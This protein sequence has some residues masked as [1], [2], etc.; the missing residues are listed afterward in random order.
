ME[1]Y[2][3]IP[4][5]ILQ[6][7]LIGWGPK[8]C[9]LRDSETMTTKS[10]PDPR[11]ITPRKKSC[12]RQSLTAIDTHP[13]TGKRE[14]EGLKTSFLNLMVE[15]LTPEMHFLISRPGL[16]GTAILGAL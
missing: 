1:P 11:P 13:E 15:G 5:N 10:E 9:L 6:F 7:V 2:I 4:I 12:V 14:I 3:Q 8:S 16:I